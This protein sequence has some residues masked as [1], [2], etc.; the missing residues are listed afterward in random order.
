MSFTHKIADERARTLWSRRSETQ[1]T[2][3]YLRSTETHSGSAQKSDEEAM[4]DNIMK[5]RSADIAHDVEQMETARETADDP[6]LAAQAMRLNQEVADRAIAQQHML[7]GNAVTITQ[8]GA[9]PGRVPPAPD[10]PTDTAEDDG[11]AEAHYST[12]SDTCDE[13]SGPAHEETPTG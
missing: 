2:E 12:A 5:G 4:V 11:L 8:L 1:S 3:F 6:G 13:D 10:V 7:Y 9:R